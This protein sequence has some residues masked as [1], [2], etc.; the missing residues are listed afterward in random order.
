MSKSIFILGG[1]GNTGEKIAQ[2]LLDYSDVRIVLGARNEE[3]LSQSAEKLNETARINWVSVDASDAH[4]LSSAFSGMDMV[5]SAGSTAQFTENVVMACIEVGCDYLDVHYSTSKVRMLKSMMADMENSG[6]CFISEAGF[7]PGLLA[8]LVRYADAQMDILESAITAGVINGDWSDVTMTEATKTEFIKELN[9]YEMRFL[10]NGVWKVPGFWS[11]KDFPTIDFRKPAGEK[12]CVPMFF[13]ELRDLPK[14]IPSLKNTGFYIA[15]FGWFADYIVMPIVLFMMK[16]FPNLMAKP[17]GNLFAWGWK[18]SSKPP[19]YTMLKVE[20][21]GK[22]NDKDTS[23]E[24]TL[25]HEDGYDFT[26][27]P[28]MACL[29]QYLDGSIQKPG[30][31]WMG[32]LVEPVRLIADMEKMGIVMKTENVKTES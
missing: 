1:S 15:G 3:K 26:A 16:L 4:S 5:V 6:N 10:K 14:R 19:Y 17:M 29:L 7:H 21:Q 23:F 2:L 32:Q 8:A 31:H 13:E 22:K 11:M 25:S 20:A 9:D 12:M 24:M 27:I 30:L 18:V 28:V